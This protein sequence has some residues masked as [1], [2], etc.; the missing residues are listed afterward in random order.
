MT[1]VQV[2]GEIL[3]RH[4][5]GQWEQQQTLE[6]AEHWLEDSHKELVCYYTDL[7]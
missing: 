4:R 3:G 5:A 6:K 7:N 1:A 2:Q